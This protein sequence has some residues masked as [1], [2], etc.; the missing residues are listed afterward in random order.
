MTTYNYGD[1]VIFTHEDGDQEPLE[2]V[3]VEILSQDIEFAVEVF[4]GMIEAYEALVKEDEFQEA[5]DAT[6][7]AYLHE[8]TKIGDR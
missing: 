8:L 5:H 2:G 7:Y 6:T 4:F 3:V 1:K